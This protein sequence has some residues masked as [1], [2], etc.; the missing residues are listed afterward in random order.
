[1]KK[2]DQLNAVYNS[3][4]YSGKHYHYDVFEFNYE[5]YDSSFKA[6]F[7]TDLKGNIGSL[8]TQL[9]D[10]VDPV[11]FSKLPEKAMM[12]KSFLEKFV[13]EYMLGEAKV[14]IFLKGDKTLF[15]FVSGQPEYELV[16]YKGTTFNFKTLSGFS[17]EFIMDE[18]G[19]VTEAKVTQPNGVFTAKKI[20]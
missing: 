11:I 8:S 12:E 20:K 13:G 1:M 5:M 7:L 16:P 10:A 2:G 14:K 18:S 15:L 4:P 9:E 6:S 17:I 3:M 19:K